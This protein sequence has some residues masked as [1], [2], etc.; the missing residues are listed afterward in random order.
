M[1]TL[2]K[3]RTGLAIDTILREKGHL[4][5]YITENLNTRKLVGNAAR[6]FVKWRKHY[7]LIDPTI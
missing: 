4:V 7:W 3:C 5:V 6:I 2:M 1:S